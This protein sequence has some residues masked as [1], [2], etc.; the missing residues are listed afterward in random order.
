VEQRLGP[1]DVLVNNAGI[2]P[3]GRF[4]DEGEDVVIRQLEI[5]LHAVIHGTKEAARRMRPRGSGHI[6][7]IASVAGLAGLPG[8][9][10]YSAT[11]FGVVGFSQAVF[12]ELRGTGVDVSVVMPAYVNTELTAGVPD[13]R[14]V[15]SV[16][17]EQV[18]DAIIDAVRN[19]RYEVY[20][21]RSVGGLTK[22]AGLLPLRAKLALAKALK[23]DRV[24]LEADEAARGL[25]R[26][27]RGERSGRRAGGR[28]DR[29]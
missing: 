29:R 15:K 26:A 23:T 16:E 3:T 9:A 11:K 18:A 28:R 20:V 22:L 13:A 17:P 12:Q 21:P 24:V 8:V 2:M 1:L 25:P 27:G 14:G 5:N 10:T 19:Q 7:N 6:V 4:E